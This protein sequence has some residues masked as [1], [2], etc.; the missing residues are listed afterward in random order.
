M[1]LAVL[2]VMT[3]AFMI[4]P[5]IGHEVRPT[6]LQRWKQLVPQVLAYFSIKNTIS[7]IIKRDTS[8]VTALFK[9]PAGCKHGFFLDII[10]SLLQDKFRVIL[11]FL[12]A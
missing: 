10:Y 6:D 5:E 12:V 4:W 11:M 3:A 9:Q 2:G 8:E 7:I 1:C